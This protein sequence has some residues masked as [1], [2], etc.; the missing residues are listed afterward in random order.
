MVQDLLLVN[1]CSRVQP[2]LG[3][4]E[5]PP[6]SSDVLRLGA[7]SDGKALN[8]PDG[9]NLFILIELHWFTP[10]KHLPD[11]LH[12]SKESPIRISDT[13]LT[14]THKL[15]PGNPPPQRTHTWHLHPPFLP[16][17]GDSKAISR[18]VTVAR[19]LKS[20]GPV[21]NQ[22]LVLLALTHAL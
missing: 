2:F 5:Q 20:Q 14:T 16:K 11:S 4:K 9:I 18:E 19:S 22:K 1:A 3:G 17:H 21:Q 6:N 12:F 15:G 7:V 13:S 8:T 10:T